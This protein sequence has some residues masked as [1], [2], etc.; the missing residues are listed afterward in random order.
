M[1][2]I[3]Y[4]D[5]EQTFGTPE[6]C[7]KNMVKKPFPFQMYASWDDTLKINTFYG[8]FM[9]AGSVINALQEIYDYYGYD[10]IK[11][12]GLDK[13]GGCAAIRKSR[14]SDRYSVHSWGLAIDYAPQLGDY[15]VPSMMPSI[16]VDIFREYGFDWGGNWAYPDGMH[17]TA[18]DE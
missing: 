14:G 6:E 5:I 9:I 11:R 16:V 1:H 8:N 12:F 3:K 2:R 7:K 4:E 13:Y 10:N 15:G 18:V 17:F